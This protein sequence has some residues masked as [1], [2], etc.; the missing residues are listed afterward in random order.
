MPGFN[1]K[2]CQFQLWSRC[3]AN[4]FR[5]DATHRCVTKT[6]NSLLANHFPAFTEAQSACYAK[7]C[8]TSIAGYF[9]YQDKISFWTFG[10]DFYSLETNPYSKQPKSFEIAA[11]SVLVVCQSI[12][13]LFGKAFLK[14]SVASK[15]Q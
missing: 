13:C 11:T 1:F 14:N 6:F 10:S 12:F 7:L 9:S 5:D 2:E 4:T 8:S 15:T 3:L